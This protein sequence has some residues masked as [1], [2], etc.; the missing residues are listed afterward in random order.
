MKKL[1]AGNKL[2]VYM[3]LCYMFRSHTSGNISFIF[4]G[5]KRCSSY[6]QIAVF[7]GVVNGTAYVVFCL[8]FAC[9]F[10]EGGCD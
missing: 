5:I 7:G 3:Y 8:V 10:A 4:T 6:T 1:V 9:R 2:H